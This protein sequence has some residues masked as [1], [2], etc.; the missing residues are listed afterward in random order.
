MHGSMA[1][2]SGRESQSATVCAWDISKA[3]F[4]GQQY[5]SLP[6]EKKQTYLKSGC[7]VSQREINIITMAMFYSSPEFQPFPFPYSY[8]T[9][10]DI[11]S[12][13]AHKPPPPFK[14]TPPLITPLSK[15]T[16]PLI[17][18]LPYYSPL[19]GCNNTPFKHILPNLRS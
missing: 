4:K 12:K 5:G 14:H 3:N 10:L 11:H 9:R 18:P 15:H 19:T 1:I 8:I 16:P 2:T 13:N 6:E 7:C 17:T